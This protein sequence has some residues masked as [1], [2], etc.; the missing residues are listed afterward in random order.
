MRKKLLALLCAAAL[1]LS[2]GTAAF[3]YHTSYADAVAGASDRNEYD[4]FVIVMERSL[5]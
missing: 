1:I 3:G 2:C 4:C 5:I